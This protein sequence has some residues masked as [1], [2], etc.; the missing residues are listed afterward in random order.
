M[1]YGLCHLA[2][3]M[4]RNMGCKEQC[5]DLK[6]VAKRLRQPPARG[7]R[8]FKHDTKAGNGQSQSSKTVPRPP[9]NLLMAGTSQGDIDLV[10]SS[11]PKDSEYNWWR[12][13]APK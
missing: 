2:K 8:Y 6:K 7:A 13:D 11:S 5:S 1:T 3:K 12:R 4:H 10:L 9:S